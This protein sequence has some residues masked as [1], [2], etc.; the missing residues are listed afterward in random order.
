M[1]ALVIEHTDSTPAIH[2]DKHSGIFEISGRSLPEEAMEFYKPV[3]EW[4]SVYSAMPNDYTL[5]KF[6]LDYINSASVRT[7]N[8]IFVRLEKLYLNGHQVNV[9]WKYHIE[10]N[11]LKETGE[12]FA[13]IYKLPVKIEGYY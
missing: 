13:E 5:F 1:N 3:L 9:E 7:I 8:D 11:E 6:V 12:E 10:D 4:I 2:L